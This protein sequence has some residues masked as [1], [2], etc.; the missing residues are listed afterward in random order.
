MTFQLPA[1]FGKY[2]LT[3]LIA[4][5]GMAEVYL[6]KAR[7]EIGG[8]ERLYAI[9]RILPELNENREFINSLINEAKITV[10]LSH[11]NI[12]QVYDLGKV[13]GDYYLA[14]DFVHGV[15]LHK[16]I[17]TVERGGGRVPVEHALYVVSEMLAGLDVAHRKRDEFGEPLRIVH[18]D[19]SPHNVLVSYTGEVKLIDFGIARAANKLGETRRGVIKGKLLYMAPEQAKALD[20]DHRADLFAVGMSLY[21]MLTGLLPFDAPNQYDIYRKVVDCAIPNPRDYAPE[22]PSSVVEVL[23]SALQREPEHRFSDAH[24]FLSAIEGVLQQVAPGYTPELFRRFMEQHFGAPALPSETPAPVEEAGGRPAW[25]KGLT[26]MESASSMAGMMRAGV[27]SGGGASVVAVDLQADEDKPTIMRLDV[28][29]AEEL[30]RTAQALQARQQMAPQ[31]APSSS[32]LVTWVMPALLGL[33]GA[34][35]LMLLTLLLLLE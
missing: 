28:P 9:K 7:A 6:A 3:K 35:L 33:V 25:A 30:L 8:F 21:R 10:T 29:K 4:R 27:G 22:L 2:T 34:G 23:S 16:V 11:G 15:D 5:G 14:M 12:A 19:I 24:A 32:A 13:G 17:E 20:I 18:R 1:Q 26:A 31:L